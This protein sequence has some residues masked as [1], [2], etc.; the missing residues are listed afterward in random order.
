MRIPGSGETFITIR[1]F[2]SHRKFRPF[3]RGGCSLRGAVAVPAQAHG[4]GR[5]R[6]GL[7]GPWPHLGPGGRAACRPMRSVPR[8]AVNRSSRSSVHTCSPR[9]ARTGNRSAGRRPEERVQPV[10][11]RGVPDALL[12]SG[13]AVAQGEAQDVVV[14]R[15]VRQGGLPLG[16]AGLLQRPK[17]CL[18][19]GE[20]VRP[21]GVTGLEQGGDA[22]MVSRTVRSRAASVLTCAGQARDGPAPQSTSASTPSTT[23][24]QSCSL[25]RT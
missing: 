18:G 14:D 11:G 23:R 7:A 8:P 19:Q 15:G 3:R 5:R 6:S 10:P 24:S 22:G 21:Q 1:A 20:G 13:G 17:E 12:V 25:L 4:A 2:H 16:Q 9:T